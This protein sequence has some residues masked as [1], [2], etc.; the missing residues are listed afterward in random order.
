M[1]S[2]DDLFMREALALAHEAEA[3]GEVPVGAVAVYAGQIIG[4]GFNLRESERSPLA[5]AEM[6]A[7]AEA[8]RALDAWRLTGVTLYVTLEPCTMCA[9]ALVLGRI[10]RVVFG[11]SD[12]KAGAVGSLYNLVEEPRLNHRMQVTGGVLAEECGRTLTEFFRS[13]REKRRKTIE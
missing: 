8:A 6:L 10:D 4:R 13:L 9:G 1:V 11:A 7:L 3:L 12:L 2:P 5:H